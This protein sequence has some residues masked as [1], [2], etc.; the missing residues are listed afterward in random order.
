M[1]TRSVKITVLGIALLLTISYILG[2]SGSAGVRNGAIKG[3]LTTTDGND[4]PQVRIRVQAQEEQLDEANPYS[5]YVVTDSS[6]GNYIIPDV[7]VGV[8]NISAFAEGYEL[9]GSEATGATGVSSEV[10]F[11]AIVESGSTYD[12]P[13]IYVKKRSSQ[14]AG[15]VK[16]T[17][18]DRALLTPIQNA[19]VNISGFSVNTDSNGEY[20]IGGLIPSDGYP[21]ECV[22]VGFK[23][24][25]A[26]LPDT[27]SPVVY[28]VPGKDVNY[29]IY[30]S[31]G[32]GSFNITLTPSDADPFPTFFD[33]ETFA[34]SFEYG[35]TSVTIA[36][37]AFAG[38]VIFDNV[39]MGKDMSYR[40]VVQNPNYQQYVKTYPNGT[41]PGFTYAL[42]FEMTRKSKDI[43]FGVNAS[44]NVSGPVT[45]Q[46]AEVGG[47]GGSF[48]N[49]RRFSVG[50]IRVPYG[51]I[52]V[53]TKGAEGLRNDA[54][55][56]LDAN[57]SLTNVE[58][59]ELV[60][61]DT[62]SDSYELFLSGN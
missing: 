10:N 24:Y 56:G 30:L 43:S 59:M 54:G 51:K 45:V 26:A 42:L 36:D 8:F 53:S 37:N 2:C 33:G 3:R 27:V 41:L 17:V 31:R 57:A 18:Y 13:T 55:T 48:V 44:K 21:V 15:T 40:F 1:N 29:D 49:G 12:V 38:Q 6:D 28:I 34:V 46:I 23:R 20:S 32:D 39:P 11:V 35:A 14:Q 58:D 5:R 62:S 4:L 19:T 47:K 25:T 60:I 16:G 52:V 50:P 22:A 61:S 9:S 7:P